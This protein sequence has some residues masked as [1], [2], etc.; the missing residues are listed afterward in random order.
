MSAATEGYCVTRTLR[1]RFELPNHHHK[2]KPHMYTTVTISVPPS[3]IE[4]LAQ[5]AAQG[6]SR[7]DDAVRLLGGLMSPL[8]SV[9]PD[10]AGMSALYRGAGQLAALQQGLVLAV[11]DSAV[12][13][14]GGTK[15]VYR[16]TSP[17]TFDGVAVQ[18]GPR[19]VK[20]E[21]NLAYYPVLRGLAARAPYFHNGSAAT[22]LD[23]VNFYNERFN[24][25]LTRAQKSDL[26]AFLRT[27]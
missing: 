9:V 4:P 18:L 3:Q 11:P 21:S 17:D 22:L 25:N 19:M 2:L 15:I 16:Q 5:A 13:D 6:W 1:A 20:S 27:L 24:L 10:P 23:A 8:A 7:E 14:T 12:I 26:V